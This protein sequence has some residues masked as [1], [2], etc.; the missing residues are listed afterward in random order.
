MCILMIGTILIIYLKCLVCS[1]YIY[2][3][4]HSFQS[5]YWLGFLAIK[6]WKTQTLLDRYNIFLFLHFH[7]CLLNE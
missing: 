7:F 6:R 2:S 5:P 1:Y 4:C 3:S